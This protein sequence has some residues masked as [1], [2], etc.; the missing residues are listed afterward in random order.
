MKLPLLGLDGIRHGDQRRWE[1]RD[2]A[3]FTRAITDDKVAV[4]SGIQLCSPV[5]LKPQWNCHC[6]NHI[7]EREKAKSYDYLNLKFYFRARRD[8]IVEQILV[9]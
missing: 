8:Y 3:R 7:D 5:D 9:R 6:L 1:V 2:D 4:A